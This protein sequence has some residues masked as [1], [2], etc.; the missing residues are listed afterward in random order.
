VRDNRHKHSQRVQHI[1]EGD[2]VNVPVSTQDTY[3][4]STSS[5]NFNRTS[6]CT[7]VGAGRF[8]IEFDEFGV[9]VTDMICRAGIDDSTI[10]VVCAVCK[11][12][13]PLRNLRDIV[14][15]L[16]SSAESK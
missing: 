2:V 15:Y 7:N 3:F 13:S 4:N 14:G 1:A 10:S 12:H 5:V 11:A 8:R 9:I 6:T 16:G